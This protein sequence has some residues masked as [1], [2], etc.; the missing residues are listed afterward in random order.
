MP[1]LIGSL[2]VSFTADVSPFQRNMQSA[3]NQTAKTTASIRRNMGLTEKS[4]AS[5][6]RTTGSNIRPYALIS[7]ARTFD[8][9]QQRANLLRGA[10][11]A[12]TAAFGGLGAALTTNVISRYLDTFTGLEN[13]VRVTSK[14]SAELA[15][16]MKALGGVAERSRSSLSAVATLYS[17]LSKASPD[18]APA[19]TLRRVETI[20]KALQ[21]GGAT[22][23]E[24]ASAAIQFSQAIQSNRLGGDELRAVLET[25]LGTELAKGLGVTIGKLR[26][27][28]KEGKLTSD[29]LFGALDKISGTIDG[30]FAQSVS[31]ID[32]A[33]TVADGKIIAYAGSLDDAYGITKLITSSI[34]DFGDNLET[35]IPLLTKAGVLLGALYAAKQTGGIGRGLTTGLLGAGAGSLLGG[36]IGAIAGGLL[37]AGAGA[38]TGPIAGMK[39]LTKARRDD[40]KAAREQMTAA[41]SFDVA[42][43]EALA[44]AKKAAGGD[45][46]QFAPKSQQKAV[47]RDTEAAAKAAKATADAEA[48]VNK[49][50]REQASL[51]NDLRRAEGDLEAI[52]SRPAAKGVDRIAAAQAAEKTILGIQQEQVKVAQ[53]LT[54]E[55]NNLAKATQTRVAAETKLAASKA[56]AKD[57][58]T[59]AVSESLNT[60]ERAANAAGRAFNDSATNLRTMEKAAGLTRVAFSGLLAGGAS[61]VSFL[62]GPWGVALIAATGALAYFGAQSREA[63]EEEARFQ[64]ILKKRNVKAANEGNDDAQRS[65]LIEQQKALN[66]ELKTTRAGY[67][68][69]IEP[70]DGW[71][72]GLNEADI[73]ADKI[74]G[75]GLE[76]FRRL[77][78]L[79]KEGKISLEQLAEGTKKLNLPQK[80]DL[81]DAFNEISGTIADA[82][83]AI[84]DIIKDI[85]DLDGKIAEVTVKVTTVQTTDPRESLLGR[86]FGLRGNPGMSLSD[87]YAQLERGRQAATVLGNRATDRRDFRDD[88]LGAAGDT[89]DKALNTET[90]IKKRA[91]ELYKQGAA[92]GYTREEARKLAE[93][94]LNLAEKT[95][96]ANKAGNESEKQFTNLRDKINE[97]KEEGRGAFLSDVDQKVID[98]AKTMKDGAPL[99]KQYVDALNSGN[100][101]QAPKELLEARDAL[102]Q[103][104]AAETWNNILQNYG[105]GAQ[106]IGRFADKTAELNFLLANNKITLDQAQR[107]YADFVTSFGNYK[108][109][110]STADAITNFADKAIT[111]FDN[112][113]DAFKALVDDLLKIAL[114]TLVL[115]PL[116]ENLRSFLVGL[117]PAGKSAPGAGGAA[118]GG[119]GIDFG[120]A[121]KKFFGIG[122]AAAGAVAKSTGAIASSAARSFSPAGM[123]KG[124]IPLAAIG[125]QGLG[126]KVNSQYAGRFQG[127]LDDLTAAGYP[128]S[129]LGEGGYSYRNVK[130]T[131]NL[132][133]HAFGNAIDI[134]PRENP[135]SYSGAETFSKYGIDPS[136][137]AQQNGLMWGGNWNKPDTMHFQVDPNAPDMASMKLNKLADAAD[138]TTGSF[139]DFN[140]GIGTL[141]EGL[142]NLGAG[143]NPTVGGFADMLNGV[144]GAGAGGGG[145]GFGGIFSAIGSIFSLFFHKGGKVP[146]AGVG[147]YVGK[148][149]AGLKS[150]EFMATLQK[151]E[152]VLTSKDES[153]TAGTIAGLAKK[154]GAT[155]SQKAMQVNQ[156]LVFDGAVSYKDIQDMQQQSIATAVE[157][158]KRSFPDWNIEYGRNGRFS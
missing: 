134:N 86:D 157:T 11:F 152:R 126:A 14:S 79:F 100:F 2:Y 53:Q 45:V 20:N 4:V 142:T 55:Q 67:Q 88:I 108:W 120:G 89:G 85:A 28:S 13:Q 39:E 22:A 32:Q 107:A 158:A 141:V 35:I 130:G 25:P 42:Q 18:I 30:Q 26:E 138:K 44:K 16:N 48:I 121:I 50:I 128:I 146:G 6:Q 74:T 137:L 23:Q 63:A 87:Q 102:L 15:G 52:R 117:T 131:N 95:R 27:M 59:K 118:A 96:I 83:R 98:I 77:F 65:L 155:T 29:I 5:F 144:G 101:S 72:N 106:L 51:K 10:L 109:I 8:T 17:R 76:E 97:L 148:L 154:A 46:T 104:G 92:L 156:T 123:T 47:T 115:D 105:E 129:S 71:I 84:Q 136:A 57:S 1:S 49:R 122:G 3:E 56:V 149:H 110:D 80:Q 60:A 90:K 111:D 145:G 150:D 36:P 81:L 132:S 12:T 93:E 68:R 24:A 133:K 153:R 73:T 38:L 112:I 9:V 62:G 64:D 94:E 40:L 33:L 66:A 143:F 127:L 125:A 37:G 70:I 75:G 19:K 82:G 119:A 43:R 54:A 7:A 91:E 139:G 58:G 140:S 34:G 78:N 114:Q 61:L 103:L 113:G 116:K 135:W 21:L 151:G 147:K 99:I 69:L 41:R 124:G 31:T